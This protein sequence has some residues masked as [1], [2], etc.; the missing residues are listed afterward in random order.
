VLDGRNRLHDA[1]RDEGNRVAAVVVEL[2]KLEV[3]VEIDRVAVVEP[4]A[5]RQ[6]KVG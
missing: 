2:G 5:C 6:S 4:R 3:F 1:A